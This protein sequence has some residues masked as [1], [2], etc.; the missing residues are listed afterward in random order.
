MPKFMDTLYKNSVWFIITL[1]LLAYFAYRIMSFGGDLGTAVRDWQ[2]W[3]QLV[4]VVWININMVSGAYDNA[5]SKGLVSEEFELA[6]KVNNKIITSVNNEM[7]DFRSYVK[8]LNEHELITIREDYLFKV[9]DKTYDEL[10]DKEKR[11]YDDLKPVRHNIYGFNLSLYYSMSK[12][13]EIPYQA[14]IKKNE[15]KLRQQIRKIFTGGLF[16]AMTINMFFNIDNVGSAFVSLLIISVGLAITFIMT[17]VPQ[18]FKFKYE[19]P[20]KVVLK[21]TLYDSYIDFKNGGHKLKKID[22]DE[23]KEDSDNEEDTVN[24]NDVDTSDSVDE[25]Q[26]T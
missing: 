13:G 11:S 17:Y 19:I 3:V 2:T 1:S 4:F 18:L 5:T 16:G 6:D 23:D 26:P 21:N 24:D 9:G 7:Q 15:G 12:S 10:D 22:Y 14:S 20:Q 25:L 8:A